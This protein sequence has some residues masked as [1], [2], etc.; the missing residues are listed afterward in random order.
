MPVVQ[1]FPFVGSFEQSAIT[2]WKFALTIGEKLMP[3]DLAFISM[4]MVHERNASG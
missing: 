1:T 3:H 2:T 4:A